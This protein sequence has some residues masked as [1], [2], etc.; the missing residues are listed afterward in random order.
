MY[1]HSEVQNSGFHCTSLVSS[2]Y[3]GLHTALT[4]TREM[5]DHHE[6]SLSE[7]SVSNFV[8]Q[9]MHVAVATAFVSQGSYTGIG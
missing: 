2:M 8:I 6:A 5:L 7:L 9:T 4:I 1:K 3:K